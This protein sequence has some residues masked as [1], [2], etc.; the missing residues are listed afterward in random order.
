[1]IRKEI[2]LKP[3]GV[4]RS[5][6][7]TK[8]EIPC[9]GYKSDKVGKV[10]VFKEFEEGLVDI[11]GFSHLI[12]LYLFHKSDGYSLKVKP[13][14]DDTLRGLFATRSPRRP[15]SLGLSLVRLLS[16]KENI[17]QIAQIDILVGTPLLD[18]KP[19]V[20]RFDERRNMKVGWLEGKIK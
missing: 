4:I 14:L 13:F 16:R 11:D 2:V 1:M 5:P 3:I 20:P 9:Q 7:K 10:E 19:Y 12:L 15:N 8:E 6:Y 18:I 17:L